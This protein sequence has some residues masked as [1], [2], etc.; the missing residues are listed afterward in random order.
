M[1]VMQQAP[2]RAVQYELVVDAAGRLEIPSLGLPEGTP[3]EVIV[4][5]NNQNKEDFSDFLAASE[6]SL[7]FWDNALDDEIW[8][9]F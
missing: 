4:L 8:N 7:G 5:I 9:D 3:V 1:A 2:K 6:S